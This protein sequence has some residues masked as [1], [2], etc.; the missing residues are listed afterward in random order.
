[1]SV[2]HPAAA[3]L[4]PV[5]VPAE[6]VDPALDLAGFQHMLAREIR[7]GWRPEE[8]DSEAWVFTGVPGH[9][10][11]LVNECRFPGC[12]GPSCLKEGAATFREP[13]AS[14]GGRA[15]SAPTITY[16]L[17]GLNVLMFLITPFAGPGLAFGVSPSSAFSKLALSPT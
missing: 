16:A 9:V 1:M 15:I 3:G 7:D 11:T 14:Y 4:A 8:W 5:R 10:G 12:H 2:G 17:I 6:P 13:K